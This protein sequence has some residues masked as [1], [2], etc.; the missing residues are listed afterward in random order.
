MSL[1]I[2]AQPSDSKSSNGGEIGDI[3]PLI[4][5]HSLSLVS[6]RLSME[7]EMEL[8]IRLKKEPELVIFHPNP[9]AGR[10]WSE[11]NLIGPVVMEL[12]DH[13]GNVLMR[14]DN[15][16]VHQLNFSDIRAGSYTLVFHHR[17]GKLTREMLVR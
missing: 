10:V 13:L 11:H 4:I 2:T 12:V 15:L 5:D 6:P 7:A 3:L 8:Y 17:D 9:S 14:A 16:Q 1:S